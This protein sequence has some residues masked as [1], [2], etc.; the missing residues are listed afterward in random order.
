MISSSVGFR[1]CTF[2]G[3]VSATV[4]IDDANIS[5]TLAEC[6]TEAAGPPNANIDP[7]ALQF[8]NNTAKSNA[9]YN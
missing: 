3:T 9:A 6:R 8:Q 1:D 7:T 5:T 2:A 4:S